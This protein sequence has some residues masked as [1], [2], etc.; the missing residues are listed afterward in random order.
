MFGLSAK[1]REE[2]LILLHKILAYALKNKIAT[3]NPRGAADSTT[4][5]EKTNITS[6]IE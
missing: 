6:S 2:R 1:T 5:G 3:K 4:K